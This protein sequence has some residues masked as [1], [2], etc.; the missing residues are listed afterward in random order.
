MHADDLQIATTKN[1]RISYLPQSDIVFDEGTLFGEV[2]KGFSRFNDI[3]IT[4]Y[5][6]C[7]TKLLRGQ[8]LDQLKLIAD[9]FGL[10]IITGSTA[11]ARITSYNV[12]YTKL[13]RK[14]RRNHSR[15]VRRVSI[16]TIK[17]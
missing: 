13:L 4:S 3:R 5:N 7:Y 12:C 17:A 8:Y 6:V 14:P 2:E 9:H 16:F 10:P 11:N 15:M 1:L